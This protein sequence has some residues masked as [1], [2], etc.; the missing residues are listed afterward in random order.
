MDFYS[1]YTTTG[2][3]MNFY[4]TRGCLALEMT[5]MANSL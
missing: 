5:P 3:T 2:R 4:P 1:P